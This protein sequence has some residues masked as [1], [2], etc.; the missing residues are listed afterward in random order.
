MTAAAGSLAKGLSAAPSD[1]SYAVAFAFGAGAQACVLPPTTPGPLAE[2]AL[3]GWPRSP[4]GTPQCM[5]H[6]P[7]GTNTALAAAAADMLGGAAAGAVVQWEVGIAMTGFCTNSGCVGAVNSSLASVLAS[8]SAA[9]TLAFPAAGYLSTFGVAKGAAAVLPS[10]VPQVVVLAHPD[11]AP[12]CLWDL[13]GAL[14]VSSSAA[15]R[16]PAAGR[17]GRW[18]PWERYGASGTGYSA[19]SQPATA[20]RAAFLRHEFWLRPRELTPLPDRFSAPSVL[21]PNPRFG[22]TYSRYFVSECAQASR[23]D[24]WFLP[25]SDG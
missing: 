3:A 16:L 23:S 21:V 17:W 24:P 8:G 4:D 5:P 14:G 18:A 15:V 1:R 7:G 2:A 20:S 10:A 19:T 13:T 22:D 25:L 6:L 9:L 11:H 12:R